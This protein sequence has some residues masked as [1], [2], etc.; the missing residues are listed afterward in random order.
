[1]KK[2]GRKKIKLLKMNV[3]SETSW[4]QKPSLLN[5]MKNEENELN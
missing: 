4:F 2:M 3:M 5:F 1:M